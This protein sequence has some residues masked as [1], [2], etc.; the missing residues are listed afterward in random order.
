[1]ETFNES[2]VLVRRDPTILDGKYAIF[3]GSTRVVGW[4]ASRSKVIDYFTFA[5]PNDTFIDQTND[6]PSTSPEHPI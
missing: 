6:S 1:M 5:H 4:H 2:F 3:Y